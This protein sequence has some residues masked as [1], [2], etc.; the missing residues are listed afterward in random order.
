MDYFPGPVARC[1]RSYEYSTVLGFGLVASIPLKLS[2][3]GQG[4]KRACWPLS[5]VFFLGARGARGSVRRASYNV[6]LLA[7][8]HRSRG[9]DVMLGQGE[10]IRRKRDEKEKPER[11]PKKDG[12]EGSSDSQ[13]RHV[14]CLVGCA[15]LACTCTDSKTPSKLKTPL[16]P[17]MTASW[18]S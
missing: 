10:G 8:C 16:A 13:T 11:S 2:G 6:P 15:F 17:T 3:V 14:I 1:S 5:R 7:I 12:K 9:R 4:C 18:G